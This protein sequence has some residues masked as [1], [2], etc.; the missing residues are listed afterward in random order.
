MV[1]QQYIKE[2]N[3]KQKK[4][5]KKLIDSTGGQSSISIITNIQSKI[6]HSL[7][8][9]QKKSYSF[10]YCWFV[11][12]F[13][14]Y[15]SILCDDRQKKC[16]NNRNEK[17]KEQFKIKNNGEKNGRQMAIIHCNCVNIYILCEHRVTRQGD[18]LMNKHT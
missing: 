8:I 3:R 12:H 7:L 10:L 9:L 5:K 14:L 1:R 13:C 15:R 2:K 17:T 6:V 18:I 16:A 4:T 11:I